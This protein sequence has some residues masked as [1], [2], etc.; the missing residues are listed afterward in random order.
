MRLLAS[1]AVAATVAVAL[2]VFLLTPQAAP[3]AYAQPTGWVELLEERTRSS[4]SFVNLANPSQRAVSTTLA[5]VHYPTALDSGVYDAECSFSS[6]RVVNAQFDGWRATQC[7]WHYALGQPAGEAD[8]WVGFGG[9]Q[10]QNW[11]LF[12]L[13]RVGYLHGPTRAWEDLGGPPNYDR[14]NLQSSVQ[15]MTLGY[16]GPLTVGATATWSDLWTTPGGGSLNVT[17]RT[18][19]DGLKEEVVIN[20]AARE[21]LAANR[22]PSTPAAQTWFGFVFQLNWS[23]IPKVILRGLERDRGAD[24]LADGTLELRDALDRLLAFMPV[25]DLIVRDGLTETRVPLQSRLWLDGD[26]NH[27]LLLGLRL[28]DMVGLPSG[29]LIFDPTIDEQVGASADDGRWRTPAPFYSAVESALYAGSDFNVWAR[30]TTVAVPEASTIDV[31]YLSVTGDVSA[32]DGVGVETNIQFEDADN[33]TA[34]TTQV[35]CEAR[36]RTTS[37]TVW[38]DVD[39]VDGVEA[40]SPSIVSVVQ[41]IVDRGDWDSGDSMVAF[42]MD[43]TTGSSLYYQWD[44]YDGNAANAP[45][46]HIEYAGWE[47][48]APSI[49]NK[50]TAE[51]TTVDLAYSRSFSATDPDTN[52]TLQWELNTTD[53]PFVITVLNGQNRT[54]WVNATPDTVGAFYVN[55]TVGDDATTGNTTDFVNY[56]L[57]VIAVVSTALP[58]SGQT[59]LL[60]VFIFLLLMLTILGWYVSPIFWF[61]SGLVFMVFALFL[62]DATVGQT[63]SST[64]TVLNIGLGMLFMIIGVVSVVSGERQL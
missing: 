32:N 52:Q 51:T 45:K 39:F 42:V 53:A 18:S 31:A 15:T 60:I 37:L 8:G 38:D 57:T 62:N 50:I 28:P 44:S 16:S 4:K 35:D 9:R 6:R 29:D 25:S 33:P 47:N 55:I 63:Y 41:E 19:G 7:G 34:C 40:N 46:L 48:T 20:Q 49:T 64:M 12:R 58:L 61:F 3:L 27:Y 1:A 30:F 11:F 17:W 59:V 56:T 22:P 54:T 10:G 21:W 13:A 5:T 26:G 23:D 36:V 14:A 2:A 43:D 24:F